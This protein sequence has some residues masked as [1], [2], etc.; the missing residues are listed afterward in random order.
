MTDFGDQ[1]PVVAEAG[2]VF[3]HE[4]AKVV[5]D[6]DFD[7]EPISVLPAAVVDEDFAGEPLSVLQA[8]VVDED[9][10]Q[11]SVLAADFL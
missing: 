2:P 7:F 6:A 9:V 8:A 1:A 4:E 11:T 5:L 10:G 3:K